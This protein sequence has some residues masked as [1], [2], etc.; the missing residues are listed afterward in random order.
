MI[1]LTSGFINF[2]TMPSDRALGL[3]SLVLSVLVNI[4]Q[5]CLTNYILLECCRQLVGIDIVVEK[6]LFLF[7]FSFGNQLIHSRTICRLP[8]ILPN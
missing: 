7:G 5:W 2:A 8:Q 1:S 3:D 6:I 4:N